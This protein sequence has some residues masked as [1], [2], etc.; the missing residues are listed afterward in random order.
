MMK[1]Y[2][3]VLHYAF[4]GCPK[5]RG[6]RDLIEHVDHQSKKSKVV[7]RLSLI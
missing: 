1:C 5:T 2:L 6:W 7:H 3:T 4:G